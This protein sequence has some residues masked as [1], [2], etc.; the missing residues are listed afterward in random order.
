M[1]KRN[2]RNTRN[3]CCALFRFVAPSNRNATQHP[4]LGGVA[5]LRCCGGWKMCHCAMTRLT[6]TACTR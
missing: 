1:T 3:K 6:L 2:N 4:S 5:V